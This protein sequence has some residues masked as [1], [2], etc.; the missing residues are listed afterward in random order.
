MQTHKLIYT[1][2][3]P[4]VSGC[5]ETHRQS[6]RAKPAMYSFLWARKSFMW[7]CS[8][9]VGLLVTSTLSDTLYFLTSRNAS[10]HKHT[11]N[12]VTA[13]THCWR[14]TWRS[15]VQ[16]LG[17]K[18]I[19]DKNRSS[20]LLIVSVGRDAAVNVYFWNVHSK[21]GKA[22]KQDGHMACLKRHRPLKV[23]THWTCDPHNKNVLNTGSWVRF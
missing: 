1:I 3:V 4:W 5:V 21:L 23:S 2:S 22:G 6:S 9:A 8:M 19:L 11:F 17:Q 15:A 16:S 13:R 7:M 14:T 20:F 18:L 12:A 10:A